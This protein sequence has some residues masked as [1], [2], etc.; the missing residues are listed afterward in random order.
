MPQSPHELCTTC[1]AAHHGPNHVFVYAGDIDEE[2]KDPISL[3]PIFDGVVLAPCAHVFSRHVI[4]EC[5]SSQQRC[6]LCHTAVTAADVRGVDN[7]T[8]N[9][10]DKLKVWLLYILT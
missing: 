7:I 5:M 3:D 2:F 6:P 10:L 8:R 1:G 4:A 9:M